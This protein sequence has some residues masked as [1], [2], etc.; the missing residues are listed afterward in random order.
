MGCFYKIVGIIGLVELATTE[1]L[2]TIMHASFMPAMGLGRHAQRS[3][4]NTW[5]KAALK[6]LRPALENQYV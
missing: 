3:L 4:V 1:L 6:N 5:G 2:F